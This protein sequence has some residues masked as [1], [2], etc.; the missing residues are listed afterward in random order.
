MLLLDL[1]KKRKSIRRYEDKAI[2]NEKL[3]LILEA[4][5]LAPSACNRQPWRFIIIQNQ[6][7]IKEI[8]KTYDRS[9]YDNY[10]KTPLLIVVCGDHQ[11]SWHRPEDG[12]DHLDIDI[13][14][15]T[16]QMSLQAAELNIGSCWI[17]GFDADKCGK[18][19]NLPNHIEPVVI[20]QLGYPLKDI[21]MAT[22]KKRKK[23]A[24]IIYWEAYEG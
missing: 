15:A 14:I 17:C 24:D 8:T 11:H 1:I 23:L 20:L 2:E 7:K 10:R 19:L 9:N 16:I 4:G 13:A 5:R 6:D 18:V 3:E 12:K 21:S 22:E